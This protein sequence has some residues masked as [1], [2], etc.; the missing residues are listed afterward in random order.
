MRRAALVLL[1]GALAAVGLTA[2]AAAAGVSDQVSDR[3]P[4]PRKTV[5]AMS[6][7]IK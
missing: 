5:R 2:G 3:V 4:A 6:S 7:L 1:V